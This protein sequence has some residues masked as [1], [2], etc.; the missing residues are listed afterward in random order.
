[1][2]VRQ[3]AVCIEGSSREANDYCKSRRLESLE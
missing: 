1:M 2:V 3:P